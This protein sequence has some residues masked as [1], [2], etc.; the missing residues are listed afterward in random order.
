M[1][2]YFEVYNNNYL[3]SSFEYKTEI[4]IEAIIE[5]IYRLRDLTICENKEDFAIA[6]AI[7]KRLKNNDYT[8]EDDTIYIILE[9]KEIE[10]YF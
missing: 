7:I 1:T 2:Y 9:D 6:K 10:C 5:Y 8:L 3:V 4:K